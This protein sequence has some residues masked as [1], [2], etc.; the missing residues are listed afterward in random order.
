LVIQL[1]TE[2]GLEVKAS[3]AKHRKRSRG[4]FHEHELGPAG[5]KFRLELPRR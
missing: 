4:G 1:K 2:M 3:S 5:P